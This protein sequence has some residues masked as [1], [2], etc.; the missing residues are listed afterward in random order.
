[1]Y[2]FFAYELDRSSF[3]ALITLYAGLFALAYVLIER[4][5]F[6]FWFL[7]GLGALLRLL[8]LPVI[9]NLSQDFYRFIWDGQ[10]MI[11]GINPYFFTPEQL[12]QGTTNASSLTSLDSIHNHQVLAAGMG[13]LNASH[14]SNYPPVN[15]LFFM[16]TTLFAKGSIVGSVIVLRLIMLLADVGILYFGR[17]LLVKLKLPVNN[18]FWYFLNPFII[19]ELTGNLH[20]E[21][22]MLFF[23]IWGLYQLLRRKWRGAGILIGISISVK[24]LPLL[25]LPLFV[26]WFYK[27]EV[28]HALNLASSF[29]FYLIVLGTALLTFAPFLSTEFISNFAATIGLWFQDFEF[30]ASVYYLIRWVG[31]Q[32]VGWNPIE[33]VGKV[34]P[35]IIILFILGLS[36]FRKNKTPQQLITALLLAVSFY[37]L[38][39]TTVHPWYAATPLLL[40]VFTRYK[41]AVVWSLMVMLSYSAY[42]V[43]GFNENLWWVALEY[44]TVIGVAFYEFFGTRIGR[45]QAHLE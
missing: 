11:Q 25:L 17:K 44:I 4:F 3:T 13:S 28:S 19:I 39:S 5:S 38:L 9:P 20:F 1:M 16:L 14:Y 35:V 8:F 45:L 7:A 40:S 18:I 27:K 22:V 29:K 31:F 37:F 21:G 23:F 34:L 43:G 41:F 12:I 24:L 33:T 15:Q 32:I 6:N 30:N 26:K 36:F 2:V 42:G 10:L